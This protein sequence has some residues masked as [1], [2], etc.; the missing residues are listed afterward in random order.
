[1]KGQI[2]ILLAGLISG[3][4]H[5]AVVLDNTRLWRNCQKYSERKCTIKLKIHKN[6]P[7][8]EKFKKDVNDFIGDIAKYANL[9]FQWAKQSANITFK[10]VDTFSHSGV[11]RTNRRTIGLNVG[12]FGPGLAGTYH[13]R[14]ATFL[15]E[16]LHTLGFTHEHNSENRWMDFSDFNLSQYCK[17]WGSKGPYTVSYCKKQT[18]RTYGEEDTKYLSDYDFD[19]I[20]HYDFPSHYV[21][22]QNGLHEYI[23]G[24]HFTYYSRTSLSLRDKI[25]LVELYPGKMAVEDVY[26]AH[27]EDLL[28]EEEKLKSRMKY[29]SC[30]IIEVSNPFENGCYYVIHNASGKVPEMKNAC[31]QKSS[32]YNAIAAM[33][34]YDSCK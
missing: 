31:Y 24:P 23:W 7:D 19:S 27:A 15:H 21:D 5:S 26:D 1:M 32:V 28:I 3:A 17:N 25:A 8:Q 13:I 30:R 29:K 6:I 9:K 33:R 2:V 22:E 14:R 11:G 16:F 4:L 20:M 12:Y 34:I 10:K 18:A